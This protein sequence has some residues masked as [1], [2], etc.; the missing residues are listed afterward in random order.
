MEIRIKKAN[1]LV[2]KGK[3]GKIKLEARKMELENLK[4][5]KRISKNEKKDKV[6]RIDI[7][8]II[9]AWI[10]RI[11]LRENIYIKIKESYKPPCY[12]FN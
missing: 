10:Y 1:P 11:C 5:G 2:L 6:I 4:K 8:L 3:E 12:K 7:Y 9:Y